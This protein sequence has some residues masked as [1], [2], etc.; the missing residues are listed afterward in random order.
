[1][2][3]P[4]SEVRH[5]VVLAIKEAVNNAI[6]HSGATELH[7]SMKF[8]APILTITIT[9]N[10]QG[11]PSNLPTEGNGIRNMRERLA[12][13]NGRM[14]IAGVPGKGTRVSFEIPIA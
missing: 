8:R 5:H 2:L 9:D 3:L 1:M 4:S 7:T 14:E 11:L 13:I 6:R 12:L 10:G